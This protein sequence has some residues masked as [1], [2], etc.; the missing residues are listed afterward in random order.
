MELIS[1]S[2]QQ[3]IAPKKTFLQMIKKREKNPRFLS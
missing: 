1:F 3:N 2:Q